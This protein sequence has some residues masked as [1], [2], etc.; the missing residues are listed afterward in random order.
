MQP[1]PLADLNPQISLPF[2]P[3]FLKEIKVHSSCCYNAKDFQETMELVANG[4]WA[5]QLAE[6]QL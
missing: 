4:P 2:M 6:R 5:D 1:C 3:F